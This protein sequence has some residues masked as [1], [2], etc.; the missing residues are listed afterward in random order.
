MFF[1]PYFFSFLT[2]MCISWL[3]L[4]PWSQYA[5]PCFLAKNSEVF[6]LKFWNRA[7]EADLILFIIF[8]CIHF[9]R[10]HFQFLGAV[11]SLLS[12]SSGEIAF[13]TPFW[14]LWKSATT[15]QHVFTSGTMGIRSWLSLM[16]LLI[17]QVSKTQ[18]YLM[19]LMLWVEKSLHAV[20]PWV[21]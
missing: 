14:S 15:Q 11:D 3:E 9:G 16:I 13:M 21:Q 7:L 6:S 12:T 17:D 5:K 2:F 19:L 1:F 10:V 18:I 20:K 8:Q 4:I